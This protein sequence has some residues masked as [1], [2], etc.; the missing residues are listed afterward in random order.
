M[1]KNG[2]CISVVMLDEL[3]SAINKH[4]EAGTTMELSLVNKFTL[5]A[6]EFTSM[7]DPSELHIFI[8]YLNLIINTLCERFLCLT[9]LGSSKSASALHKAIVKVFSELNVNIKNI[10]LSAFDGNNT[11]STILIVFKDICVSKVC[12]GKIL[13]TGAIALLLIFFT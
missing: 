10:F 5:R 7:L 12:F 11:I 3:H 6:D 1:K 13:V 4:I 9:P 8:K 2:T